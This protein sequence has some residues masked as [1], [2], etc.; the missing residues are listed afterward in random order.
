MYVLDLGIKLKWY[1]KRWI[2]FIL[3]NVE[4]DDTEDNDGNYSKMGPN[5][6]NGKLENQNMPCDIQFTLPPSIFLLSPLEFFKK[7]CWF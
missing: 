4:N 1:S 5:W 3:Q 6:I 7:M 2:R